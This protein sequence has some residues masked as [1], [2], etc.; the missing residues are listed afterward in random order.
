[1]AGYDTPTGT[2]AAAMTQL[3][4]LARSATAQQITSYTT[5]ITGPATPAKEMHIVLVDNG[6]SEMRTDPRFKEALRCIRCAGC[7]NICPPYQQFGGH[8]F[9]Y[10]YSGAIGL[11]VTPFHHGLES[12]AG[13]QILCASG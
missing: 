3:R 10:I 7:A 4:L 11:V 5:F 6:R 12:D 1:M 13:P 9:G 8:V 2:S